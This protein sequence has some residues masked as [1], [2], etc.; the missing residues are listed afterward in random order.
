MEKPEQ[1]PQI[2]RPEIGVLDQRTGASTVASPAAVAET[3]H[4]HDHGSAPSFL[5]DWL[6]E[7]WELALIALA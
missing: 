5:P 7:R 2:L 3:D 1:Y 6:Q 4:D